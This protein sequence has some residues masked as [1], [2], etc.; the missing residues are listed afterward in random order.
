MPDYTPPR[1]IRYPARPFSAEKT[2][3]SPY[4]LPSPAG[5]HTHRLPLGSEIVVGFIWAQLLLVTH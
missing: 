3:R 5:S 2:A 1:L 4:L